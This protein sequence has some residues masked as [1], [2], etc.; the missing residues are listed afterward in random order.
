MATKCEACGHEHEGWVPADRLSRA[1]QQRREA[2]QARDEALGK[3]EELQG[4]LGQ[5]EELQ[6]QLSALTAER[7]ALS[8]RADIMTAGVTDPEGVS[9]VSTLWAALP[10]DA[11]PPEGLSGWLTSPDAPR[12][13]RVYLEQAAAAPAPA[14][15]EAP[16]PGGSPAPVPARPPSTAGL[17]AAPPPSTGAPTPAEIATMSPEEYRAQRDHLLSLARQGGA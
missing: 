5:L 8:L 16:K 13:V 11:R 15:T 7:D 17:R 10:D 3:V 1:T 4:S 2:E 12:A 6:G 9:I 14:P